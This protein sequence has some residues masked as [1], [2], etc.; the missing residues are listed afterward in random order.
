MLQIWGLMDCFVFP[1]LS[2]YEQAARLPKCQRMFLLCNGKPLPLHSNNCSITVYSALSAA[3]GSFLAAF[4]DGINPPIS[5]RITLR[6]ISK[7]ALPIGRTAL[8]SAAPVR[9]WIIALPGINRSTNLRICCQWH[10]WRHNQ[11]MLFW[12][13][14]TINSLW[15]STKHPDIRPRAT[16]WQP[17]SDSSDHSFECHPNRFLSIR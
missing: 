10:P 14:S 7:T 1:A 9:E 13:M 17:K 3:T 11:S 6:T 15:N 5:V 2:T 8:I 4:L 16:R 12:R